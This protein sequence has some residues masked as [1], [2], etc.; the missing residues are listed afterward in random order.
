MAARC[1]KWPDTI[2][3]PAGNNDLELVERMR[4]GDQRAFDQFFD[5][6]APRIAGFAARRSS[7]DDSALEDVVQVT[8]IKAV[9]GL[10]GFRG[11][12][13][14]F[15]WLCQICRNHLADLARKSTRQP[16]LM[17]FEAM[18]DDGHFVDNAA[19]IKASNPLDECDEE[20]SRLV[21]RQTINSLPD[22]Q[23]RILKLRFGEELTVPAI[24]LELG[25]SVNAA[26]LRLSRAHRA[27]RRLWDNGSKPPATRGE[28]RA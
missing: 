4:E 8:L 18:V 24:A 14:L 16:R 27:F 1:S 11:S 20:K 5:R 17:S 9:K 13:S 10:A 23:A 3:G 15:T 12:S 7:L 19:V 25:I 21:V 6:Y 2:R 22:F 28:S 26:E